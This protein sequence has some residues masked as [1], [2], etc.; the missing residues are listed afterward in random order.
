MISN[1][2]IEFIQPEQTLELRQRNLKPFLSR[3]ECENP[4]DYWISTKHFGLYY[5][6]KMV[7]IATVFPQANVEFACGSPF[8]LRGMAT[9]TNYRGQGFG[10]VL[11]MT[12]F[13]YLKDQRSDL[14]WCNARFKALNFYRNNGFQFHGEIFELPDIGPHRIMY[15]RILPK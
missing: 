6:Q 15:K 10:S 5:S 2:K 14:I 3:T 8:R 11:L 12:I 13:D 4:E 1:Y 9:D 7:A